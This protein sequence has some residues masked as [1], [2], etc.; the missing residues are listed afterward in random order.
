M[1]IFISWS[2]ERSGHLANAL[3]V[4]LPKVI[5]AVRP[6]L[7]SASIDPGTRWNDEVTR[8]L[9]ELRCGVLCLTP[10]NLSA[11]WILFEAGAL[12]KAVSASRVIPYL[13]GFEP[14]ELQGPL[15]QF[16]AV[17]A[18]EVGTLRLVSAINTMGEVPL[19]SPDAL[20]ET[21]R[22]WWPQ[23]APDIATLLASPP[24]N[25]PTPKRS[26]E[27]MLG[28][29]L[30]MMRSQRLPIAEQETQINSVSGGAAKKANIGELIKVLRY[31]RGLTR[32]ETAEKAGISQA[33][34][35]R[36]ESGRVNPSIAVLYALSNALEVNPSM[37]L[38]PSSRE[39]NSHE[40]DPD[41]AT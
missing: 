14:R 35:S 29:M 26:V 37:L 7:S 4:W 17:Q 10:E 12:S 27:S 24:S 32:Q 39:L 31:R 16:Q 41:S 36:I 3:A 40:V 6:W 34:L 15:A 38:N 23:L 20:S 13:M 25:T 2:G 9:E 21:F 28:E 33:H 5:Q 1:N 18:D 11:P 8:A 22:V 30:D 19:L